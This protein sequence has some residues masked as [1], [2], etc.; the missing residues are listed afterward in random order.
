MGGVNWQI[1]WKNKQ[2]WLSLIPAVLLLVQVIA[3]PF[4]YEWDFGVLNKQLAAIVNA[5]FAVLAI[6]GVVT[7]PT[8]E[9][10]ADSFQ[11][12]T[13]LVPKP[14]E[15][16]DND[17]NDKPGNGTVVVAMLAALVLAGGIMAATPREA[18][19]RT[20]EG[21]YEGVD[22]SHWDDGLDLVSFA[23]DCDLDFT[24]IKVGG[25]EAAVGGRYRDRAFDNFYNQA[26]EAGL[27]IG[28]YYYTD[29]T[30]TDNARL[31]AEHCA[32]LLDGYN[33]DMPVYMDIEDVGQTYLSQREL[34]DV[35]ITFCDTLEARGYKAG[36]YTSGSWWLGEVYADELEQYADWVAWWG[37]DTWPDIGISYGMWQVG[38]IS[39]G[40]NTY[41]DPDSGDF[42]DYDL[43]RIEYWNDSP[44]PDP[45]PEPEPEPEPEPGTLDV[46]GYGGTLTVAELQTQLGTPVDS[47]ITGQWY[48]NEEFSW[49]IWAQ[50]YDEGG[51]LCVEALQNIVGAD[52]DGYW[53]YET[54]TCTQA[55]LEDHGYDCG[56]CGVDGYFGHDSVQ[57]LQRALNDNAFVGAEPAPQPDPQPRPERKGSAE[58]VVNAALSTVGYYAPA[59]P[60]PGS[61]PARWL[62]D[63]TG[64]DWLRGPSWEIWW[65]CCFVSWALNQG[66]VFMSGAP[67]YNTDLLYNGGGW[68]YEVNPRSVQ[69][70]DIVIF[71]WG[72][73]GP[74]T[75]HIGI[76][77]SS[78]DGYGF[79]TVEGNVG[80]AV[81]E[82]YRTLDHVW[83]VLRPNY[84]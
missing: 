53:G 40:H 58:R 23:E 2:F 14:R 12:L 72:N 16:D 77:T 8:T 30:D 75:D 5:L 29:V 79:Y 50:E 36:I 11:A 21:D 68:K 3:A 19:A 51:S 84:V 67:T 78:F 43:C 61:F 6:L 82:N 55:W 35:V 70:G 33:I 56:P 74:P 18:L 17:N 62:A 66:D 24:I 7:D 42:H 65:C 81:V 34:T 45:Q 13:Y 73:D 54:S 1:R 60:E 27:H 38:G 28:A 44:Q 39:W 26:Q 69:Y 9:G 47:W 49:A 10:F 41:W 31:D 22:L 57:A 64:E 83:Y 76:A 25:D 15:N 71:D 32:D 4:G 37:R 63:V 20:A 80:N 46:D 52:T 59:D 48:G